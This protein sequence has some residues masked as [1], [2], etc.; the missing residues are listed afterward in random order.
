MLYKWQFTNPW[1][2][3]SPPIP[4]PPHQR[5]QD[6]IHL[7]NKIKYIPPHFSHMSRYNRLL[8]SLQLRSADKGLITCRPSN[9]QSSSLVIIHLP[10][11]GEE[12]HPVH[13]NL[14]CIRP[15]PGTEHTVAWFE[16]A[17]GW[18]RRVLG[19]ATRELCTA[20]KWERRLVWK[21][22]PRVGVKEMGEWNESYSNA[23]AGIFLAFEGYQRS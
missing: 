20:N 17:V 3:E 13:G 4:H 9:E 11:Y 15:L 6:T 18:Y 5:G 14:L 1:Q 22:G 10:R 19:D 23:H 2:S 21:T 7:Q 12:L 16:G 8:T